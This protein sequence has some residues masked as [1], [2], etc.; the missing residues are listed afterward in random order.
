MKIVYIE[1]SDSAIIHAG[2]PLEDY[3]EPITGEYV[4]EHNAVVHSDQDGKL[5]SIEIL[6]G[7][8][9]LFDLHALADLGLVEIDRG[10]GMSVEEFRKWR[11]KLIEG[12]SAKTGRP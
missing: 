7:A 8:S 12:K 11:E 4:E 1:E 10:K 2:L 3:R 6:S 5:R 9:K